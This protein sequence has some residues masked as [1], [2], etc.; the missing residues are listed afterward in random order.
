MWR[1][2]EK[3]AS[4]V[5]IWFTVWG[6]WISRLQFITICP[7]N[8]WDIWVWNTVVNQQSSQQSNLSTLEYRSGKKKSFINV[9]Y[10][11]LLLFLFQTRQEDFLL[12][13]IITLKITVNYLILKALKFK[14]Q[15][16]CWIWWIYIVIQYDFCYFSILPYSMYFFLLQYVLLK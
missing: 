11:L 2:S 3:W 4:P 13:H 5:T 1:Y 12:Q 9:S 7:K 14:N 15:L 6:L 8:C 10:G 16:F